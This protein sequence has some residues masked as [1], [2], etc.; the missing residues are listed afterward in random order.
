M[1]YFEI[2]DVKD[3]TFTVESDKVL[4][5]LVSNEHTVVVSFDIEQLKE[6]HKLTLNFQPGMP[7]YVMFHELRVMKSTGHF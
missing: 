1:S 6:L 3:M 4:L 2:S 7:G 5:E